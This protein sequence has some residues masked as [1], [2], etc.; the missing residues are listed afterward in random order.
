MGALPLGLQ[1]LVEVAR[2]LYSGAHIIILDEP[3][4]ALAPPEVERLFS[5]LRRLRD[6]GRSIVFIS[7]FL[8][9][10]L[11]ICDRVTVFRNGQVVATGAC[12]DVNK[13]WIIER[14]IGSGHEELEESY[15]AD[16]ALRSRP[17]A[18]LVLEVEGL[19]RTGAYRDVSFQVHAG[20]VLGVYGFMGAGQLDLARTLFG[21][22]PPEHGQ[23]G[24]D[25]RPVRLS[26]ASRA[27]KLGMA[28]VPE[29]RR[30]ML[31]GSEPM[32]KNVTISV[33]DRIDRLWLRPQAERSI[34]EQHVARLRI[35][36]A[37]RLAHACARCQAAISRKSP[38][39]SG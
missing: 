9:D 3:T 23:I 33:L 25:G 2:V 18:R 19:G 21:M 39:R 11:A 24:L 1:Q 22:L 20:E 38:W 6:A 14:M 7:H 32:F 35:R 17:D 13:R 28:F 27:R 10:V 37:G 5:L 12:A 4:S 16:I 31:F 26:S 30:M 36:P 8:D 34:A 29:S 15:L